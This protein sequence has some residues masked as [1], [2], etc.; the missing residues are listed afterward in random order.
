MKAISQHFSRSRVSLF[1][2]FFIALSACSTKIE[3]PQGFPTPPPPGAAEPIARLNLKRD[4]ALEAQIATIAEMAKGKVGVAAVMLDTGDAALLNG[5]ERFPMQS[6]YKLPI[7]MAIHDQVRV[8]KLELDEK[9]GVTKEDFVR[10]GMR[11]PLRDANPNGGEFTIRE[12]SQL[13]IVESDGTASDVLMRVAG[14]P[15]PIQDYLTQIGIDGV[16]VVNTE[17]EIGRD[18]QT[19]YANFATP[20]QAAELL[21]WLDRAAW[22]AN[23]ND[24][25]ASGTNRSVSTGNGSDRGSQP[26][27]PSN[28][29]RDAKPVGPAVGGDRANANTTTGTTD[30]ALTEYQLLLKFMADSN[31]GAK[32]LK[33]ELPPGTYVAHKTGTSGTQNGITAATNDIGIIRF[34]NGKRVAIAVFVSDSPADEK[35][36]EAVIAKIAKA[37][38]DAWSFEPMR[39]AIDIDVN[40]IRLGAT[41]SDVRK[42]LGNPSRIVRKERDECAS[43]DALSAEYPGLK[44]YLLGDGKMEDFTVASIEV[45]SNNWSAR[46]IRIGASAVSVIETFGEPVSGTQTHDRLSYTLRH[47]DAWISFDFEENELQRIGVSRTLC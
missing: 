2:A 12:L 38:W 20:I 45:F 43:A 4:A 1:L 30:D 21:R 39:G 46:G 3:I 15:Q 35:T 33:G 24:T 10:P 26:A 31:P 7:S 14:G 5:D 40:S 13:S 37:V 44:L 29:T 27:L 17:K 16:R 28:T 22:D 32:R 9:V 47:D 41:L 23:A 19:Q 34:P 42:R 36:R 8:G 11:S 18:W 25:P 6:V